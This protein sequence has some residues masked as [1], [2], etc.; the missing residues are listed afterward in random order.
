MKLVGRFYVERLV[1]EQ[2][3]TVNEW[4]LVN[5]WFYQAWVGCFCLISD[6][7]TWIQVYHVG[8]IDYAGSTG[9]TV[10]EYKETLNQPFKDEENAS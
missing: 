6:R 7:D 10:S 2:N 3:R 8:G 1:T 9:S 4:L 5:D